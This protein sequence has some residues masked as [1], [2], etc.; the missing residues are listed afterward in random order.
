MPI[1]LR[2]LTFNYINEWYKEQN[3]ENES[4]QQQT[5]DNR[6]KGPDISPS[7]STTASK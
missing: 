1:W 2:R 6:P 7:Y 5:T 3:E 4:A